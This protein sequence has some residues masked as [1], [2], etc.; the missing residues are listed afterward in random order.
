MGRGIN[1]VDKNLITRQPPKTV[2]VN[3]DFTLIFDAAG[4]R[5]AKT[6]SV[7]GFFST[8][9]VTT[10]LTSTGFTILGDSASD[11]VAVSAVIELEDMA[12]PSDPSDATSVKLF[13]DSATGKTSV[14]KSD[15]TTIPLENHEAGIPFLIDGGGSAITTGIKGDIEVPFD[16]T[17]KSVRMFADT[18]T[19]T[20]VDIWKDTF[21]NFPPTDADSITASAVPTITTSTKSEDATLTGWT[22]TVSK[23]DIIRWNVDSNDNATRL[24]MSLMVDRT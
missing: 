7:V 8:L 9:S 6:S 14:Q 11:T 23:G 24:T 16:C 22:T 4:D 17:I 12:A 3:G 19:T 21:A 15:S 1:F 13:L 18:S 2:P 5:L 10:V 20:V